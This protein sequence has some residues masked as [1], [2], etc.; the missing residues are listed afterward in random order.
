M[1]TQQNRGT[2]SQSH[3]EN[4]FDLAGPLEAPQGSPGIWDSTLRTAAPGCLTTRQIAGEL[5]GWVHFTFTGHSQISP[6]SV[7]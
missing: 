1:L 7:Y 3:S 4:S 6:K 2:A 5:V